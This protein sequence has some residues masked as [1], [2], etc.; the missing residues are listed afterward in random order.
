MQRPLLLCA[1]LFGAV[2]PLLAETDDYFSTPQEQEQAEASRPRVEIR[3]EGVDDKAMQDNILLGLTLERQ[4]AHPLLSDERIEILA[5][6]AEREI[7]KA[8]TPFGYYNPEVEYRLSHPVNEPE[9]WIATFTIDLGPPVRYRQLDIRILGPAGTDEAFAT[10]REQLPL[11]PGARLV[12]P[13]YESAKASLLQL[14]SERGYRDARLTTS[15]VAVDLSS[16]SA[17]LTLVLDGGERYH[18]G[19]VHFAENALRESYL[20]R[21]VPFQRGDFYSSGEL[22]DLQRTLTDSDYFSRITLTQGK[23]P[24]DPYEVPIQVDLEMRKPTR[25]T[26]GLGYGTDTGPRA[27]IGIERRYVNSRGHQV[28]MTGTISEIRRELY[29][30]YHIPLDNPI[31]DRLTFSTGYVEETTDVSSTYKRTLA[32]S[33]MHQ[34]GDWQRILSLTHERE[35]YTIGDQTD[36]TDLL[37]PGMT[38]QRIE[39]DNRL[40]THN[41]WLLRI[42]TQGA[43]DA[44]LS[45]VTYGQYRVTAKKITSLGGGQR[46]IVR[47]ELGSTLVSDLERLPVSHRFFAGGDRSVRGFNYNSLGPIDGN[48]DV[49]GGR[50]LLTTSVELEQ[51][52]SGIF[53]LAIFYDAGNALNST[54]EMKLYE[55]AGAGLRFKLPFGTVRL[56]LAWPVIERPATPHLHIGLGPDL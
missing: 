56:D 18:F 19:E 29:T 9:R 45:D 25:Y 5:R 48:G 34:V 22:L 30:Y 39:A 24:D 44:V 7:A 28:G 53:A 6:R 33:T 40:L 27:S 50:H 13:D 37:I 8:L 10:W 31:T 15:R 2:A 36:R 1:L 32:V 26:F 16:H 17:D 20:K 46:F 43:S 23:D 41:G 38:W 11:K 42:D 21:F 55:G 54:S 14:C 47:S 52:I 3:L 49:I 4:K 12:H 35:S 51:P